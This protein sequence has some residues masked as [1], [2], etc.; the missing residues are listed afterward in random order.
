[1]TSLHHPLRAFKHLNRHVAGNE[2]QVSEALIRK[3]RFV[4]QSVLEDHRLVASLEVTLVNGDGRC[5]V[6]QQALNLLSAGSFL[7]VALIVNLKF[8]SIKQKGL[9]NK[10]K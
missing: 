9:K 3:S 2:T 10:F 5:C 4:E 6:G 8:Y 1:M 7:Q